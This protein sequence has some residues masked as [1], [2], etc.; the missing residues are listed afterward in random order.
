MAAGCCKVLLVGHRP[1]VCTQVRLA[2]ESRTDLVVV[3]E[4]ANYLGAVAIAAIEN[5]DFI[6]VDLAKDDECAV[7]H[8][9]DLVGAANNVLVVSDICDDALHDQVVAEG[10]KDLVPRE[11]LVGAITTRLDRASR[12]LTSLTVQE[13]TVIELDGNGLNYEEVAGQLMTSE[14]A[15][16]PDLDSILSKKKVRERFELQIYSLYKDLASS[17]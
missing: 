3:G 9:A 12:K 5:P 17:E 2:I 7:D 4:A 11:E 13:Q 15:V 14:A 10:A 6:V 16:S 8:I 1:H